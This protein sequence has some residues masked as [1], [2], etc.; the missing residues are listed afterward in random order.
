MILEEREGVRNPCWA[1]HVLISSENRVAGEA[2]GVDQPSQLQQQARLRKAT[3]KSPVGKISRADVRHLN[4]IWL[5]SEK[6]TRQSSRVETSRLLPYVL[7]T[8]YYP[9]SVQSVSYV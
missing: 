7:S 1:R 3:L 6:K 8:L 5:G 9:G 2:V 4:P